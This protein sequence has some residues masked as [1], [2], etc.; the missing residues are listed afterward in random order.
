MQINFVDIMACDCDFVHI[1]L[2]WIL[3]KKKSDTNLYQLIASSH[4]LFTNMEKS[5]HG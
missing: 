3:F 2:E 1:F 4:Q 5:S